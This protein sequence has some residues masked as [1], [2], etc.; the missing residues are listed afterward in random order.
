M[1][2]YRPTLEAYF[3]DICG[4]LDYAEVSEH[5]CLILVYRYGKDNI[6]ASNPSE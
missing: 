3:V 1:Y 6:V 4:I 5:Y 2:N